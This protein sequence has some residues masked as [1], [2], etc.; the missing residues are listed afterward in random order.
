AARRVAQARVHDGRDR[1]RRHHGALP[2]PG[3]PRLRRAHAR[4][5]RDLPVR[6]TGRLA[7]RRAR[8]PRAPHARRHRGAGRHPGARG[9]RPGRGRRPARGAQRARARRRRGRAR[10]DRRDRGGVAR[11]PGA[12]GL[13]E[14]RVRDRAA[15]PG[16]RA[17][18]QATL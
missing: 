7:R 2:P 12:R 11:P 14:P 5:H 6:A 3:V 15:Q 8:P 16:P 13:L 4:V 9:L 18:L 10:G 17:P 1:A